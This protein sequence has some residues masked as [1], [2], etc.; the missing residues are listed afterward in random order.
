M[1]IPELNA[2]QRV[3][4]KDRIVAW[5]PAD[6]ELAKW[7]DEYPTVNVLEV[8]HKASEWTKTKS[9]KRLP[10]ARNMPR[11]LRNVWLKREYERVGQST[12]AQ[13]A[14]E[15][16]SRTA[17]EREG[18]TEAEWRQR[19]HER[20]LDKQQNVLVLTQARVLSATRRRDLE[21]CKTEL[22]VEISQYQETRLYKPPP[23]QIE[24]EHTFKRIHWHRLCTLC[25]MFHDAWELSQTEPH[26][27]KHVEVKV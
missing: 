6:K 19:E 13:K 22:A 18:V 20:Y 2:R 17:W 9:I 10:L 7:R 27:I 26:V 4:G 16:L 12:S 15:N 21:Q 11:W 24:C 3:D 1:I 25:G 8:L 23:S 5:V 14:R